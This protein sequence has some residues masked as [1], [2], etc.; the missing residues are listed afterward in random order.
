M[1][2][3]SFKEKAFSLSDWIIVREF[4]LNL[5]W[6]RMVPSAGLSVPAPENNQT[7]NSCNRQT[8]WY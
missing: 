3:L 1:D 6:E 5:Q 2:C 4:Y 7:M 8:E